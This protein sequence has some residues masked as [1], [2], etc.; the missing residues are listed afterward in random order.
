HP[1]NK[2]CPAPRERDR[3]NNIVW[4]EQERSRAS[5]ATMPTSIH[6][7]LT[8]IEA[9]YASGKRVTAD[10]YVRVPV[11]LIEDNL[12][13]RGQ[14]NSLIASICT[15]MPEVMRSNLVER[16]ITCFESDPFET[17]DA[18]SRDVRRTFQVIHFAWYNRHC[19]QGHDAPQDI[20]PS[21]MSRKGC[22]RTNHE[23]F[24]PYTSKPMEEHRR[25][26]EALQD[27]LPNEYERLEATA[28][29]LPDNNASAV[30]PFVALAVNLNVVTRAHRDAQD[31]RVCLVL[32]I[33]DFNGG[34]L[35]IVEAGLVIPLRHA[36]FIVFPSC[37]FTH[38]NLHYTG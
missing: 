21:L 31:D 7:L 17:V 23:Q 19:T 15:S 33:G 37:E 6:D 26:Y 20:A 24:I 38:F 22:S 14:G 2:R 32:P 1:D 34:E 5:K 27:I 36:D 16:L 3:E 35:C 4:T 18:K 13:I 30:H 28:S 29:I 8:E 10:S 11:H 25:I 12:T 9:M